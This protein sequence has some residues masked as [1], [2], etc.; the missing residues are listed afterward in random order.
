MWK[1]E[2]NNNLE[3]QPENRNSSITQKWERIEAAITTANKI[4]RNNTKTKCMA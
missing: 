2:T 4:I 1:Q 3:Q